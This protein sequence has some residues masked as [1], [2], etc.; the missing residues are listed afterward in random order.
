[1]A[2]KLLLWDAG[3]GGSD[4]GAVGNGLK[5]SELAIKLVN[6]AYEHIDRNYVCKQYKDISADSLKVIIARANDMEADLFVSIHF[7]AFKPNIG[8]GYEALV[9]SSI[10]KDLGELFEKHIK[11]IGQNSRGVKYRPDLAVLRDTDM[12]AILNEIAFIDTKK[13]IEDWDEDHEL[14]VMGEALAEAAA[15]YL[16]LPKKVEKPQEKQ[17][18]VEEDELWGQK[19]SRYTQVVLGM[20]TVD[21]IISNQLNSCKKYLPNML[22]VSWEFQNIAR[23]GSATIKALQELVGEE[24]DGYMGINTVKALQRF[25]KEL[26]LYNGAIDGIAGGLTVLGWQKYLNMKLA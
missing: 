11:A 10:N 26:G 18:V 15:E 6:Y 24:Q 2:E 5:E 8:D 1:M 7:N 21:S 23:G 9:H 22:A 12:K 3:H 13:D 19:T 14:K 25:L 4:P 20:P 17:K 16:K